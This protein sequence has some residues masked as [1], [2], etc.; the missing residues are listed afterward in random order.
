MKLRMQCI[1]LYFIK[2]CIIQLC[3]VQPDDLGIMSSIG[4]GQLLGGSSA[5]SLRV[6]WLEGEG[7][8]CCGGEIWTNNKTMFGGILIDIKFLRNREKISRNIWMNMDKV[9]VSRNFSG[10]TLQPL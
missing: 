10:G 1:I 9:K 4:D 7:E 6:G 5:G 3:I 2:V 8:E